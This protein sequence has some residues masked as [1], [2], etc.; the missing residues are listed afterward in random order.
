MVY[1]HRILD[2]ALIGLELTFHSPD[3]KRYVTNTGFPSADKANAINW[4]NKTKEVW[5]NL[6][7]SPLVDGV[8]SMAPVPG[9]P[10][11]DLGGGTGDQETSLFRYIG[12]DGIDKPFF[13][14]ELSLDPGVVEVRTMPVPAREFMNEESGISLIVDEHIFGPAGDLGFTR[15]GDD[16]GGGHLNVDFATG[17][18]SSYLLVVKVVLEAENLAW[19]LRPG[20]GR[21]GLTAEELAD[22][23]ETPPVGQAVRSLTDTF[24]ALIDFGHSD[25][26]PFLSSGRFTPDMR[27]SGEWDRGMRVPELK[28]LYNPS[29]KYLREAVTRSQMNAQAWERFTAS[30]AEWLHAHP[31][32]YQYNQAVLEG[33][34]DGIPARL[35]N[36]DDA[37]RVLHYQAVNVSHVS[38]PDPAE[39]RVEFR[40]FKGQENIDD[41]RNGLRLIALHCRR[42]E[43]RY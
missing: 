35:A 31:T 33:N 7:G 39:S 38:D 26:D 14:W 17:F 16:A 3:S 19:N 28:D 40:F 11:K 20:E 1:P 37:N 12:G 15:G 13:W 36:A 25:A 27:S 8:D 34:T 10:Q 4:W 22:L 6:V 24:S 23:Y 21:L 43:A 32:G 9:K 29:V 42:A 41:I 18:G 2:G 5:A 30:H